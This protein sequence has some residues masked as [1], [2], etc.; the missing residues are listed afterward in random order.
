MKRDLMN[1]QE[2]KAIIAVC[3]MAAFSDGSQSEIERAQV[4]RIMEG[5]PEAPFD[6]AAV[7]QE[8][9]W[10]KSSLA[11]L[12]KNLKSPDA[13][14]LAYEMAVCVC[15][16]DGVLTDAERT[17]LASL[18]ETLGLGVQAAAEIHQ[19]A[20]AIAVE[21]INIPPVITETGAL[22]RDAEL[23]R[24]VLNCAILNG[25]LELMPQSLATMAIIPLQMRM[26]YRIGKQYG[27]ELGGGHVKDF[28]A[29]VGIG[30][31]SQV[32]ESFASKLVRDVTR[33]IGGRLLGG[34][35]G[36]AT[37]SAFA[38]AT[39]YALGQVAKRYYASGRTLST[40]QLKDTFATLLTDAKL[41]QNRYAPDMAQRS[42]Q[43]KMA[44]LLPLIRQN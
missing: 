20:D 13:K 18:R 21:A 40:A 37:S 38:F 1:E 28:L 34:L 39:T 31:T 32:V 44:E 26:V 24:M 23:D 2:Q 17:F 9:L 10:K 36:Q 8:V 3:V 16:A 4:Q 41:V 14:S 22:N 43:I 6:L 27:F 7:Y 25:A 5:F 12:T 30:L 19:Q 42:Q 15:H 29:T 11:E 33:R 35:A